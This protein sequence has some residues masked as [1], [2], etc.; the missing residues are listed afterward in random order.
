[1]QKLKEKL[2]Y[3]KKGITL[4]ALVITIIVLLILAGVTIATLTSENGILVRAREARE[5]T[6]QANAE[7]QVEL[8]IQASIGTDG[9][10]NI[11]DLNRNLSYIK[12]LTYKGSPISSTNKIESLVVEVVVDGCNVVIGRNIKSI[13][14]DGVPIPKGFYYVGGSKEEGVI[15]SDNKNDEN[16]GMSHEIITQL[17]GN[18]FVWIPVDNISI[19]Q[20]F[21]GYSNGSIQV[22]PEPTSEPYEN[23][24]INEEQE[25]NLMC[26]SVKE[27]GGFYIGRYEASKGTNGLAESKANANVW[28]LLNWGESMHEIGTE[29]VVYQ[30]KKMY[31]ISSIT[32]TL[33]YGIQWDAIMNFIDS[34][35][36]DGLCDDNSYVVNSRDKGNYSGN[37]MR[38]ASN[39]NYAIKN[40]YDLAGNV[41]EWTMETYVVWG[42]V[43]RGGGYNSTD[44]YSRPMSYR[45][46]TSYNNPQLNYGFRVALY[47]N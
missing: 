31:S 26:E 20:R 11:E 40:I 27:Y 44:G 46:T 9:K 29:G 45:G 14:Q 43:L 30:A 17:Q 12:N 23:G 8:A 2:K 22:L 32:S 4:I 33:V 42:K 7:E 6:K 10:I 13:T 36:K 5:K 47:I 25:Y 41:F 15:I 1:M 24:Y 16:K 21:N 38:T 39:E 37:I 3:G 35:Y 19:F 18:Q 28:N 34:N